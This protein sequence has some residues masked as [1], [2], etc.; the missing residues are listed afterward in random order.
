MQ[1]HPE[2]PEGREQNLQ[3]CSVA[4][5]LEGLVGA[6]PG[7]PL[8]HGC[9]VDALKRTGLQVYAYGSATSDDA[10]VALEQSQELDLLAV[11]VG[12]VVAHQFF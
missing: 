6:E 7:H 9:L 8:L 1:L 4:G 2:L 11:V 5:L 3:D 10:L 12:R